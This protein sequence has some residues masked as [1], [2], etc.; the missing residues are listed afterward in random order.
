[1]LEAIYENAICGNRSFELM[2]WQE[3]DR[4]HS[5]WRA[6]GEK[7][8]RGVSGTRTT[9]EAARSAAQACCVR[10]GHRNRR[11]TPPPEPP[12]LAAGAASGSDI[13]NQTFEALQSTRLQLA[14][15]TDEDERSRLAAQVEKLGSDVDRLAGSLLGSRNRSGP[16]PRTPPQ[17]AS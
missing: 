3:D 9:P 6:T 15:S 7:H 11:R 5:A 4:W 10:Y 16:R 13:W 8:W 12:R 2:L 1:M 14:Q 17:Q